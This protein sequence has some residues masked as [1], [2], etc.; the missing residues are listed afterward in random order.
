VIPPKKPAPKLDYA[1]RSQ[2]G[3]PVPEREGDALTPEEL[4]GKP[5]VEAVKTGPVA[6]TLVCGLCRGPV[7]RGEACPACAP[8][9]RPAHIGGVNGTDTT[10]QRQPTTVMNDTVLPWMRAHR[11]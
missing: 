10:L 3:D 11:P 5:S 2:H 8:S 4:A 1:K 7:R 9:A 6:S